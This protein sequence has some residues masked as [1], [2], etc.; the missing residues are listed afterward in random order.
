V[1][2]ADVRKAF[3]DFGWRPVCPVEQG[4]RKLHQ[5]VNANVDLLREVIPPPPVQK[6]A[7]SAESAPFEIAWASANLQTPASGKRPDG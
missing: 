6:E 7:L 4:I 3:E 1:F 5:W 2:V